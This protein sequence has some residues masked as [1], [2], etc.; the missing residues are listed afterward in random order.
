MMCANPECEIRNDVLLAFMAA[1]RLVQVVEK[2]ER[3][4][5]GDGHVLTH[6]AGVYCSRRCAAEHLLTQCADED[7]RR[8]GSRAAIAEMN[9][10]SPE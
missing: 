1:G 3:R 2:E 7:A 5:V 6:F 4:G 9:A 8:E 10:A